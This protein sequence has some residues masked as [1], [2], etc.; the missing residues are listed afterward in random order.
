[1]SLLEESKNANKFLM[2]QNER[3]KKV[4]AAKDEHCFQLECKILQLENEN[5]A[6]KKSSKV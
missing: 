3:L 5:K 4:I 6:L 1:M 2:L